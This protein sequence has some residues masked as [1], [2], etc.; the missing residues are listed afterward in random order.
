MAKEK[1]T[2][3]L[4]GGADVGTGTLL[5]AKMNN[6]SKIEVNKI[7]DMFIYIQDDQISAS[8]MASSKL[9]YITQTDSDGEIEFH[10]VIGDD[11]LKMA[12]VFNSKINRPMSRGMLSPEE[13][14]AAPI[15]TAMFK[16]I[17]G[18]EVKDGQV[19]F[20]VPSQPV[21]VDE[22]TPVHFHQEMFKNIFKQIG[23]KEAIPLNEA[24]AIIFSECSQEN[25]TGIGISFGAGQVN[26]CLSYKGTLMLSFS[27]GRSGDWID[28]YSAN[29][30]GTLPNKITSIK[31]KEDFSI[32]V[33]YTA[34]T[35]KKEKLSRQAISFAYTQLIEYTI[36]TIKE[37]FSLNV[38]N[39]DL[40]DVEI[41]I[42]IGGGT[43]LA[44]NF[45][46]IF[47]EK[48]N[49]IKDFPLTI[50][51]IRHAKNPL[52]AVSIGCLV[53]SQW[54]HNKKG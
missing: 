12:N 2:E 34:S 19:V 50:S 4:I 42:I 26:V 36:D 54:I 13:I 47:E 51:E 25:F 49:E 10:A 18:E 23:F 6:E 45:V 9:D 28:T 32:K 39:M 16:N 5:F 11:A 53:Y 48:F 40:D 24:H 3:Y 15:I 8:E 7:R 43:S 52:E 30:S 21:D 20:S 27:I 35:N 14:N 33:P 41:P 37:Q 1:Q 44:G 38:D 17:I 31:E 22:V 29:A 46:E